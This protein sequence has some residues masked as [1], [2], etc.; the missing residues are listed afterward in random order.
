MALAPT[1]SPWF[2]PAPRVAPAE[3]AA[4]AP[5]TG[6]FT[7]GAVVVGPGGVFALHRGR[8]SEPYVRDVR[9]TAQRIERLLSDALGRRVPV[10]GLV[11][12][13]R[14]GGGFVVK[15]APDGGP[16]VVVS[17][18]RMRPWLEQTEPV[19]TPAEVAEIRD[20]LTYV[21]S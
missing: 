2:V 14:A 8:R 1:L 4:A 16:V 20:V 5:A 17:R 19:L 21:A 12:A 15:A 9:G 13:F 6:W 11:T 7:V 3:L 10:T 18:R